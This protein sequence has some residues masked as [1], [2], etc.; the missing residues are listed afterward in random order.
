MLDPL[1]GHVRTP[2]QLDPGGPAVGHEQL[3]ERRH[4][5][6]GGVADLGVVER[7]VAPAQDVEALLGDDLLDRCGGRVSGGTV[8]RQEGSANC[9]GAGGREL[10]V[11]DLAEELV[12]DLEQ[13]PCSVAGVDLGAGG[14]AVVEVAE[15][16]QGLLDEAVTPTAMEV[17]DEGDTAG[18]VLV[19]GPVQPGRGRQVLWHGR[20]C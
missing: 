4:R 18:V 12:G 13:E 11:D 14:A 20:S 6:A 15:R 3:P 10:E 16:G 17:H 7:D 2:V 19:L 1:A 5:R 8:G 9:V